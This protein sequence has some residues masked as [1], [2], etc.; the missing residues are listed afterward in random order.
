MKIITIR[1]SFNLWPPRLSVKAVRQKINYPL[2]RAKRKPK[3]VEIP[4]TGQ[5]VLPLEGDNE[6][7][8]N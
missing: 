8:N 3:L 2:V 5:T 4:G 6:N 7:A 1:M